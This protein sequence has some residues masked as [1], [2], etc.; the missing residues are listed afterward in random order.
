M[1][2]ISPAAS[3]SGFGYLTAVDGETQP[4]NTSDASL[5]PAQHARSAGIL[6]RILGGISQPI[7]VKDRAHRFRYIN[8]AAC[9]LLGRT[10]D[11]VIG[12]TDYDFVPKEEADSFCAVDE[13]V[14]ATG[15]EHEVEEVFTGRDGVVH[16]LVTRKRR[17]SLPG[18]DGE[19][20]MVVAIISDVTQLR[21]L[22]AAVRESEG[23][24]RA[25][26]DHAPVMIWVA[27]ESGR[28]T[29]F[30]RLWTET[31]GQAE[32]DALGYGWLEVIH[33]DDRKRVV[34]DYTRASAIFAPARVEYR[35]RRRDGTWGWVLDVGQ[36]RFGPDGGFL[37]YVGSA[38]DISERR[39]IEMALKDSESR[40]ATIFAQTMVGILHRDFN[41]HVLMV[42]QRFCDIVGRDREG[43]EGLPMEAF[44]HPDDYPSNRDVWLK[45]C[46]T[47]E[48]FQ[49]EK[50]YL[51]SDGTAVWC[52]INVSF[53]FDE[54]GKPKSSIVF[55]EDIDQRRRAEHEQLVAQGQLAHMARHDMLTGL[56]N[57]ASFHERLEQTM[58]A[59]ERQRQV[60]VLSLDLD[61]FKAV[62]DTLGHPAGDALLRRV[63]ER[64]QGCVAEDDT[65]ARL[66][67][68]EFAII[69][70]AVEGSPAATGLAQGIIEALSRP[71][72][73]DGS[74][75]DIGV[76]IGIAFAPTDG[77]T[78]DDVIKAAD[79]ALYDAKAKRLGSYSVFDLD[80]HE[81]LQS[82]QTTKLRLAGAVSRGELELHYQ[83]LINIRSGAINGCE[84]LLRWRH[85][86]RGLIAPS[87]F[88]PIAEETGLIV[89]IGEWILRQA[90]CEAATWPRGI[91]VAVN[92]SPVQFKSKGLVDAVAKA[93]SVSGLEA[94]RLQLEITESVLLD[95]TA[96]NLAVLQ[97]LRD[98]GALIAMDDFG[99]GYSS[100]GYLRTF[101]FDKIKVDREFISDLPDGKESLAVLRAVSGL[102]QSLGIMTTVE[103]V[104][105][106]AQL[107]T[108]RAEGFDE[109][110]GFLFSRPISAADLR[111]LLGISSPLGSR[112]EAPEVSGDAVEVHHRA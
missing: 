56:P 13:K 45:H 22:V 104:E 93:L 42:N 21:N 90:C 62:N 59:G 109:A 68:D 53:I 23:R 17:I 110:Q 85:P 105:T 11:E 14:L 91:S 66:G 102:G 35:L 84:A 34:D 60:G 15:A 101:P 26:A 36:P 32:A 92:L 88:I 41:D 9:V 77:V 50:R 75:V 81:Q 112:E 80:M 89:P 1:R 46:R 64:L 57:R 108:V 107:A 4:M 7:F 99:T 73:L 70:V 51:R 10:R 61:G 52:A 63:A 55:V 79:I 67:G 83:P 78:T 74:S 111:L 49:L 38:L 5:S 98:L 100:L 29:M 96:S 86:E 19:E 20:Q 103:G 16:K 18:P 58:A 39:S 44:T 54:N 2:Q 8:Q 69:Q 37:G 48:P 28:S 47:G 82:R 33:P 71:F 24:F 27:D 3:I 65:V 106:D 87:E 94:R 31:T 97:E 43:L 40:L 6:D 72:D 12:H 95:D 76:S 30:N 25:M